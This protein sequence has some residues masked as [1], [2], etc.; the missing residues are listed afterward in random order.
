MAFVL[1][2]DTWQDAPVLR[3]VAITAGTSGFAKAVLQAANLEVLRLCVLGIGPEARV[4]GIE[5]SS[6]MLRLPATR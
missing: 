2:C 5:D 4:L 6:Q 3:S 1:L